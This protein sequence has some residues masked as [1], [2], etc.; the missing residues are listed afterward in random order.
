MHGVQGMLTH[1]ANRPQLQN[2]QDAISVLAAWYIHN[3]RMCADCGS[4]R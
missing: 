1:G 4:L 3:A 2:A